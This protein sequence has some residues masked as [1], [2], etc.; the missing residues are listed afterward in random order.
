[1]NNLI[2]RYVHQ[3]GTYLPPKERADI[4]Q[5]LR[6][7]IQDQLDDRYGGEPTQA[8]IS[9]VLM[10][11]GHPHL[12][13]SSYRRAEYLIG[14]DSYL[15]MM[16]FLRVVWLVIPTLTIFLSLF[17]QLT[18]P[19]ETAWVD[20]IVGTVFDIVQSTFIVSALVVLVFAV[21]QRMMPYL[22]PADLAFDPA[23]LPP[24]EDPTRIK[25]F[26]IV[27]EFATGALVT[28]IGLYFLRVG[29]LT[30]T[31]STGAVEGV[32]PVPRDWLILFIASAV[33]M[34]L[35]H[36]IVLRRRRWSIP[37]WGLQTLMEFVGIIALYFALYQPLFNQLVTAVPAL[38]D[39]PLPQ[40]IVAISAGTTIISKGVTFLQLWNRHHAQT[41]TLPIQT[42]L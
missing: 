17:E 31:F 18:T 28:L 34:T 25:R 9:A 35:I 12:M 33:M 3:V 23:N 42:T 30:L 21:F 6:S 20:V 14:P 27:L 29:G 11:F 19:T 7:L 2:E 15:Q 40:I 32:I 41:P 22:E 13:A 36:L 26:E 1:M 38:A 8:E 37:M 16:R 4:E 24:V 10:E 39:V 5:E